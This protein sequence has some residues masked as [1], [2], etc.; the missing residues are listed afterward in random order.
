VVAATEKREVAGSERYRESHF[1]KML[2]EGFSFSGFERDHLYKNLR[3]ERFLDISGL[4][5]IDSDTDGRGAAYVDLDNDGDYDI[6]LTA[7]QRKAHHLFKNR[8]G[9]EKNFLRVSLRGGPSGTDAFGAQVRVKTSQ[10]ILTKVKSGGSGFVSQ[11]DPRLLF[12]LGRDEEA[13]WVEVLWPSGERAR[14]EHVPARSSILVEEGRPGYRTLSE[15]RF[16]LPEPA[17]EREGILH[18]LKVRPGDSFPELALADLSGRPAAR[19]D[20]LHPGRYTLVNLWAT[21]CAP[22]RREMPELEKLA[23][24]LRPRGLDVVG[25]SLD[26]GKAKRKIAPTLRKLG[27]TYPVFAAE[28]S[29]FPALFAG[30][31]IFIPL[32]YL[33]GPEGKV[34]EVFKGYSEETSERIE[35]LLS[36]SGGE[37]ASR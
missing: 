5:G 26:M 19:E 31:E 23:A 10:G 6:F 25:V 29:I 32:S 14:F 2:R 4:T 15:R 24:R 21:Y 20:L 11:S 27:V 17:P 30:E 8:L 36:A 37:S 16:E 7:F 12:G 35:A 34:I 18:L 28:E 3:G 33:V 9:Q 13:E 1:G 22:C